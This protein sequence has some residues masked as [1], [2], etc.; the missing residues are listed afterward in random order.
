MSEKVFGD[1]KAILERKPES[2]PA[3][4]RRLLQLLHVS[5][6]ACM[7]EK[8]RRHLSLRPLQDLLARLKESLQVGDGVGP[9]FDQPST[10][11][12]A[13]RL[14][15][16]L[17]IAS[18]MHVYITASFIVK[19]CGPQTQLTRLQADSSD[20]ATLIPYLIPVSNIGLAHPND[21]LDLEKVAAYQKSLSRAFALLDYF[22]CT[23]SDLMRIDLNKHYDELSKQV[24]DLEKRIAATVPPQNQWQDPSKSFHKVGSQELGDLFPQL[25]FIRVIEDLAGNHY[26]CNE[27]V[28]TDR[29]YLLSLRRV[30][31]STPSC[32][33]EAFLAWKIVQGYQDQVYSPSLTGIYSDSQNQ[34]NA[35]AA[36]NEQMEDEGWNCVSQVSEDLPWALARFYVTE[37]FP[38]QSLDAS[39]FILHS[40]M[41]KLQSSLGKSSLLSP[42]EGLSAQH[43][44]GNMQFETGYPS[45]QPDITN[46]S[47]LM[48]H[49]SSLNPSH[50]NAFAN[51]LNATKLRVVEDFRRLL[52]PTDRHIWRSPPQDLMA[53]YDAILNEVVVQAAWLQPPILHSAETP[54]YLSFG[55]LGMTFGH[56]L[57]HALDDIGSQYDEN[58]H[59]T[60]WLSKETREKIGEAQWCFTEQFDN[61]NVTDSAGERHRINGSRVITEVVADAGGLQAAYD[62]WTEHAHRQPRPRL[63]GLQAFTDAQLF[64]V[65]AGQFF[66]EIAD[67]DVYVQGLEY[68]PHPPTPQ[69][70]NGLMANSAAFG[71]AWNCPPRERQCRLW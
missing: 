36:T 53:G 15:T 45:S 42:G 43:K 19:C 63:P 46:T 18:F 60:S 29:D 4:D 30:L 6:S 71:R 28:L 55:S 26:Q 31:E 20:P 39:N 8:Q 59:L 66:C 64:F 37:H 48:Q 35:I 27:T 3:E 67:R 62:A 54:A 1:L 58:G 13:Y 49:Y 41:H 21:Y 2:A 23:R 14:L 44:L 57:T 65:A 47:A 69:R 61:M 50:T 17:D 25:S 12:G 16:E 68:D 32:V 34:G 9:H 11:T 40:V 5:Y 22:P 7:N 10:L 33:V 52:H 24:I 70:V 56:E 51:K 38:Q